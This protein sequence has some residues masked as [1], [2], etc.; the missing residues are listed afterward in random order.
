[1]QVVSSD[2]G[3]RRAGRSMMHWEQAFRSVLLQD[4]LRRTVELLREAPSWPLLMLAGLQP[5]TLAVPGQTRQL[6][7]LPP[8]TDRSN[9][10][11]MVAVA[12]TAEVSAWSC[13]RV[14]ACPVS[15]KQLYVWKAPVS[16]HNRA[17]RS[18]ITRNWWA[19]CY[20]CVHTSS[21]PWYDPAA[22]LP[23]QHRDLLKADAPSAS[24]ALL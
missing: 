4:V 8:P 22:L 15:C 16:L 19:S 9:P 11:D 2:M 20:C 24:P 7:L 6:R 23:A 13:C 1:M 3:K 17:S 5:C 10:L 18:K 21:T 14:W 12:S